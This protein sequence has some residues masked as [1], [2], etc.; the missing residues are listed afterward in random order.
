MSARDTWLRGAL[1]GL[2]LLAGCGNPCQDLCKTMADF[3]TGCGVTVSDAD[4]QACRA[5]QKS[6]DR[7]DAKACRTFGDPAV[8]DGQWSC[9]DVQLYFD[10]G[11]ET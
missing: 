11:A 4:I 2:S 10:G 7:E 1:V 8:L 3:A 6:P 5:R 9:D